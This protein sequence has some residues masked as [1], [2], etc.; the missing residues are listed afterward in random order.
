M[1]AQQLSP[2]STRRIARSTGLN[3]VRA[4][5]HGKYVMPF[6]TADHRHGWWDKK[7][8]KWAFEAEGEV[9]HYTS[10]SELFPA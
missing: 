10:C 8:G 4:W 2:R 6:V 9:V 7:T 3:V 1:S 5:G